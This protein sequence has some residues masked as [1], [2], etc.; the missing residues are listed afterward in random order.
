MVRVD[1]LGPITVTIGDT[2]HTSAFQNS[3]RTLMTRLVVE[4]HGVSRDTLLHDLWPNPKRP[5]KPGTL[6]QLTFRLRAAFAEAAGRSDAF[7]VEDTATNLL[8]L[9]PAVITTRPRRL[10]RPASPG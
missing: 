4:P 5:G 3:A 2:D 9:N 1:F 7:I 8:R 10:R 6:H